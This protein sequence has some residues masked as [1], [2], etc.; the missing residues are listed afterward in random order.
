MFT[1]AQLLIFREQFASF[2]TITKTLSHLREEAH[3][4]Q[5]LHELVMHRQAAAAAKRPR[6]PQQPTT[7]PTAFVKTPMAC[8][9]EP[10][11]MVVDDDEVDTPPASDR[12]ED[13]EEEEEASTD[14]DRDSN[15]ATSEEEAN[16]DDFCDDGSDEEPR[17]RGRRRVCFCF[18]CVWAGGRMGFNH[19]HS[20]SSSFVI[21]QPTLFLLHSVSHQVQ[22]CLNMPQQPLMMST[23]MRRRTTH[24][25][26][27]LQGVLIHQQHTLQ[28]CCVTSPNLYVVVV[29]F[30][31]V[32]EMHEWGGV[33]VFSVVCG[34]YTL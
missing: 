26:G 28:L 34:G 8:N 1:Q 19:H 11:P 21:T 25:T 33:Y 17:K 18:V 16:T 7:S 23:A 29:L 12:D 32:G 5:Q 2:K 9:T 14:D 22:K 3:V 31:R 15:L 30:V 4:E 24:S 6:A 27:L 10:R 20:S 13:A